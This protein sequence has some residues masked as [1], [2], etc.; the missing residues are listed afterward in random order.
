MG[1]GVVVIVP[2]TA[3]PRKSLSSNHFGGQVTG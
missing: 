3:E 1:M 2:E